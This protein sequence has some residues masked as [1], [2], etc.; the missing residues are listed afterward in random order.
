MVTDDDDRLQAIW[1]EITSGGSILLL[2]KLTTFI[3]G[4]NPCLSLYAII[5]I[6][7]YNILIMELVST[8]LLSLGIAWLSLSFLLGW[9]HKNSIWIA[10]LAIV[11]L[12]FGLITY[13]K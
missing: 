3:Q 9:E 6:L 5:F 10:V 8:L 7:I 11:A 12:M 13:P 1:H 4:S 2:S